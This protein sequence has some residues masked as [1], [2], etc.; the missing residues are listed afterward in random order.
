IGYNAYSLLRTGRDEYGVRWPLAFQSYGDYKRPVYVYA[1][2]PSIAVF[3]PTAT[4]VRLPSALAGALSVP[5]LYAVG[6]LLLRDRRVA[7]I[8]AGFLAIS[9]WAV[10]FSRA[11]REVS[12]FLVSMLA[13]VAFLIAA[14]RAPAAGAGRTKL[15]LLYG[16]AAVAFL[17]AV[18]TYYSGLIVA[19]L[20]VL[21][22]AVCYRR[23][24]GCTPRWALA[25]VAALV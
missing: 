9:P 22:I 8:A 18:Y 7:L 16:G 23:S 14:L 15:G 12:I 25:L 19:P 2:I 5:A 4:G 6:A 24:V 10:L 11:A 21:T 13:V 17:V 1:A 3:G 20:L